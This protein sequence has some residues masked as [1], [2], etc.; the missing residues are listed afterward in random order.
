MKNLLMLMASRLLSLDQCSSTGVP[1]NMKWG[2][3]RVPRFLREIISCFSML[4]R[5]YI[6][7]RSPCC[8]QTPSR[9]VLQE[10]ECR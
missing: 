10:V 6:I 2:S 7:F 3:V 5:H 4:M 9:P 1:Q 8:I